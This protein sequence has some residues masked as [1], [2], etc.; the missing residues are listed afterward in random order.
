MFGIAQLE[1]TLCASGLPVKA[2]TVARPCS[3]KPLSLPHSVIN[4]SLLFR[5]PPNTPDGIFGFTVGGDAGT[6]CN[7]PDL[8]LAVQCAAQKVLAGFTPVQ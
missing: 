6:S 7:I 3:T 8:Y 5:Q 4:R 2:K 1:D